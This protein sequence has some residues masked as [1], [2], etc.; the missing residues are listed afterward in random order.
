MFQPFFFFL[1]SVYLLFLQR[2][3]M[4]YEWHSFPMKEELCLLLIGE[5]GW[6]LQVDLVT[7]QKK[8]TRSLGNYHQS[9]RTLTDLEG[10]D[11][12]DP[13]MLQK[14][15]LQII[16]ARIIVQEANPEEW[17]QEVIGMSF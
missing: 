12:K 15:C 16:T 6:A 5:T 8:S 4:L 2:E 10:V 14:S 9:S 7:D 13:S 11:L 17:D 3:G 1:K